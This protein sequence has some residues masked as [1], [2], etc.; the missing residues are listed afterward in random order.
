[1]RRKYSISIIEEEQETE[2]MVVDV[3]VVLSLDVLRGA[4]RH[5][6][7]GLGGRCEAKIRIF[8]CSKCQ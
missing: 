3:N 7:C 4:W 8:P 2:L 6:Y 5:Y 1:M